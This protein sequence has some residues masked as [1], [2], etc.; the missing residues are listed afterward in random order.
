MK[1]T[2]GPWRALFGETITIIDA[3]RHTLAIVTNI[4]HFKRRERGEVEA[5]ARIITAA[6]EM[7]KALAHIAE[8]WNREQTE[9]S[10]V[11]ALWHIIN[12]AY[13]AIEKAEGE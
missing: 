13:E 8:Y 12:V 9:E 1:H 4:S 6:P 3:N 5:N 10:M 7:Y 2:P 11:D